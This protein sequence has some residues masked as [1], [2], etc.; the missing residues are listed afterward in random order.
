MFTPARFVVIDDNALHAHAIAACVQELGSSCAVVV[1]S[2]EADVP[3]HVFLGARVIFM[4]L[5]LQDRTVGDFRRHFAEIQRILGQ[6]INPQGGPYMLVLWTDA[7]E[8]AEEL[9][10]YL[11]TNLFGKSPHTRPIRLLP[12]SKSDFIDSSTGTPLNSTDLGSKIR[13]DISS[14]PSMAALL[15]WESDVLAATNGVLQ[16]VVSAAIDGNGKL[17]DL[18]SVLKRI[19]IDVAGQAHAE[20]D[21]EAA[22]HMALLPLLQDQIQF[23]ASAEGP[24]TVWPRAF[25]NAPEKL[26]NLSRERAARLNSSLHLR[27][28][29]NGVMSPTSWGAICTLEEKFPW[30][31]FGMTDAQDYVDSVVILGVDTKWADNSTDMPAEVA[32]VHPA[33]EADAEPPAEK[34]VE[35][36]SEEVGDLLVESDGSEQRRVHLCQIRTGAACDFAQKAD[37]PIPYVLAAFIPVRKDNPKKRPELKPR[38]TAWM[39]PLLDI[40][41][42]GRGYLFVEPRFSRTRGADQTTSF[43]VIASIREQLL[44]ELISAMSHHASRP[45]ITQFLG[46]D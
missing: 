12:L 5:Q 24:P 7:P 21:P 36:P 27:F 6:V 22:I 10:A 8:R 29:S 30:C 13:A 18:P 3:A 41:D 11:E 15:Q 4:D 35:S 28:S 25:E 40:G 9:E 43:S 19:A 32:A 45:G 33:R 16:N 17:V 23:S 34:V 37:G 14:V 26:P 46:E 44:M 2:V 20:A 39:S 38:S 1:W 42:W 31:D